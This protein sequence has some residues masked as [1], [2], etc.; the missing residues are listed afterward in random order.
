MQFTTSCGTFEYQ[1]NQDS[2]ISVSNYS[3]NFSYIEIPE[4]IDGNPVT[5]ISAK[6]FLSNRH[7]EKLV[8]PAS[9]TKIGDWAFA[10]MPNLHTICLPSNAITLGKQVF[11]DCP[12]LTKIAV[13][14]TTDSAIPLYTASI[15]QT[16]QDYLLF[17]PDTIGSDLWYPEFDK[18]V[19]RFLSRPDE[20]GFEPV[21]YGW[22]EVE[23]VSVTQ[24]PAYIKKRRFEKASLALNRLLY[25]FHLDNHV[26]S[27]Y[28]SYIRS[29]METGI[30]DYV[31]D[32]HNIG[33]SSYVKLLLD[34]NAIL[35]EKIDI[36]LQNLV[37]K[38]ASESAA[39]LLHY[40]ETHFAKKDFFSDLKI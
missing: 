23:D 8:I 31:I 17:T 18:S 24:L 7:I 14:N 5:E 4:S 9:V 22:F 12:C 32:D 27:Q 29:N 19:L 21:F 16:L 38:N 36:Y 13:A 28:E 1:T 11:L 15:I 3:G 20:D 33:N 37:E 10:H 26:K 34:L 35:E 40:K 25:P 30:W 6:A 2:T 39:I